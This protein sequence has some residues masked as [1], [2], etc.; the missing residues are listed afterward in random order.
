MNGSKRKGFKAQV[1]ECAVS[2]KYVDTGFK[3][4]QTKNS[5]KAHDSWIS[6]IQWSSDLIKK[7]P[8]IFVSH[9][10]EETL[11]EEGVEFVQ[12]AKKNGVDVTYH[13]KDGYPHDYQ[14]LPWFPNASKELYTI[15][16]KFVRM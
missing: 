15:V 10:G 3:A 1:T 6:P 5:P 8:P 9:G 4:L 13:V 14:V 11:V 16:G 2:A 12:K 7:L